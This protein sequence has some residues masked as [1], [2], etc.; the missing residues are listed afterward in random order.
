MVENR[1]REEGL[2]VLGIPH[3]GSILFA[4]VGKIFVLQ[5]DFWDRIGAP[6]ASLEEV[7][8]GLAWMQTIM[9]AASTILHLPVP[10]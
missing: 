7:T 2:Y 6:F 3:A 1:W 5:D 10:P 4:F 9:N 8:V